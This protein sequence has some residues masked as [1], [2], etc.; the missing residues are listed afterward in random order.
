VFF[1]NTGYLFPESLIFRDRLADE[2]GLNVVTLHPGIP[3][4]QQLSPDGSLL[5]ATDPDRCCY[6]N[7]VQPLE[8]AL[9]SHDVWINGVRADQTAERRA[10]ETEQRGPHGVLRYHPLL[11]WTSRDVYR[12]MEAHQLPPHPLEAQG[13]LSVGC[14]P[15]TRPYLDSLDTRGGRWA[16]MKKRECGLHTVLA[17]TP[18]TATEKQR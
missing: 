8:P 2:L 5:F 15:C 16:G 10:M 3:K 4:T 13:Y 11:H 7:K 14:E 17:T 12:Y 9:Q 18:A 1:V 6:L